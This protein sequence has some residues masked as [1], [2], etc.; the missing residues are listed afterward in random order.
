LSAHV[1]V[2]GR[3]VPAS[4]LAIPVADRTFEHG[5]GLFETLRTYDG[6][7]ALLDRHLARLL[8]SAEELGIPVRPGSLPDR[9]AVEALRR[10]DRADGD[11][12]MR[13]TASGGLP[14]DLPATVWL[15][16]GPLPPSVKP[17]GIVVAP[18][19]LVD[20]AEPL[21]RHKTLNYWPN[22]LTLER[23]DA[24]ECLSRDDSGWLWE[25]CRGNLFLARKALVQ[26]PPLD[27]P[28]L[29]GIMRAIVLERARASGF[30]VVEAR[31]R[32]EDLDRSDEVFFTNSLRGI[33]PA[34]RT[35]SRDYPAP[36]PV[37]HRLSVELARWIDSG[38]DDR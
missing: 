12:L 1:W 32:L 4:T 7:P 16:L 11:V 30:E 6:R 22:R 31:L 34:S 37:A 23:S 19:R 17:G 2:G 14:L 24:D 3:V 28:V 10:A 26:T 27:G 35:W 9:A 33:V 29:P 13:I 8:R 25:G 15:R 5:L 18:G 21:A 36:G 38:A 20:P